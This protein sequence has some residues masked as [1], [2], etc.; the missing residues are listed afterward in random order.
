MHRNI[1]KNIML[2][3]EY[4]IGVLH[5]YMCTTQKLCNL[6]ITQNVCFLHNT[7][8]YVYSLKPT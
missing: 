5:K 6:L 3:K 7:K 4:V 8:K 2:Y 1:C